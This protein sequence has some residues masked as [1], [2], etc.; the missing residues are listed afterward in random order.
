MINNFETAG[1]YCLRLTDAELI[2]V[3]DGLNLL[4]GRY[5]YGG[6]V[7]IAIAALHDRIAATEPEAIQ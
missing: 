5:P 6:A 7:D 2:K 4:R 1:L 3:L